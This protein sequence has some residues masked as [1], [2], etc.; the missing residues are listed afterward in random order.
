MEKRVCK[1]CCA[2]KD[3]EEFDG[4]KTCN[5]CREAKR[6]C[7]GKNKNEYNQA[8]REERAK[9]SQLCEECGHKIKHENWDAHFHY[10]LHPKS[11]LNV[12]MKDYLRKLGNLRKDGKL[13][14]ELQAEIKAEYE[15]QKREIRK[16]LNEQFPN[17][18]V[19]DDDDEPHPEPEKPK[20]DPDKPKSDLDKVFNHVPQLLFNDELLEDYFMLFGKRKDRIMIE[21][22]VD[23]S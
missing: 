9:G 13:N 23:R 3:V 21:I 16:R 1:S 7:Y 18:S 11:E 15:K 17:K 8:R 14:D 22:P 5:K 2:T 10:A 6:K 19:D 4:F 12:L 20:S